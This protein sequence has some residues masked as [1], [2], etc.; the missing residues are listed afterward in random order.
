MMSYSIETH[1]HR[2]AAWAASRAASVNACRF[3]VEHGKKIIE[4]AGIMEIIDR[5]LLDALYH[6]NVGGLKSEW[7]AARTVGWSNFSSDQY[8]D[9]ITCIKKVVP[10]DVGLWSIEEYWQGF[11]TPNKKSSSKKNLASSQNTPINIDHQNNTPKGMKKMANADILWEFISNNWPENSEWI[12]IGQIESIA[13]L[14]TAGIIN[15]SSYAFAMLTLLSTV[16]RDFIIH[17]DTEAEKAIN[18]EIIKTNRNNA[19]W[20]HYPKS[21]VRKKHLL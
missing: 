4:L 5:V 19:I 20:R 15:P 3:P 11:Q 21:R 7:Q 1:R 12:K 9:L 18:D 10:K 16:R 6:K 8:E 13:P 2:F 17:E 14:K